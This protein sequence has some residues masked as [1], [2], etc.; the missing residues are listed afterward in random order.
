MLKKLTLLAI[1]VGALLVIAAPAAQATGPLITNGL[2]EASTRITAVSTNTITHTS[3]GTLECTTVDLKIH[4]TENA[5]TTAN[6]H[7]TGTWEG[8]PKVPTHTGHCGT[9]SGTV[10]EVTT[11][12]VSALHLTKHGVETTGT[13]SFSYTFDL[14]PST[15]GGLIAECTMGGTV[16]VKK[17][18]ADIINLNGEIKRTAGSAFCP[19]AGTI[20]GDFT[21]T[22]EETGLPVFIH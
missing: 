20:T 18:G 19:A 6:G 5:N 16:P 10:T 8:T 22:D 14:R 17:T 15:G 11:L 4:L 7:G 13:A 9:S 12:T 3:A 21:L 1:S 2:G